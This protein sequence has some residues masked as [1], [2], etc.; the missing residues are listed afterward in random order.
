MPGLAPYIADFGHD[1][2]DAAVAA[3]TAYLHYLGK[4]EPIGNAEEGVIY[5]PEEVVLA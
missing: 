3:Y 4:I 2:C 5:V 1:L